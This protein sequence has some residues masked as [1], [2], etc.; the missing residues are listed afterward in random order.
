MF[1][2]MTNTLYQIVK[3]KTQKNAFIVSIVLNNNHRMFS[4][5]QVSVTYRSFAPWET[6]ENIRTVPL[7]HLT[8]NIQQLGWMSWLKSNKQTTTFWQFWVP[9]SETQTKI[10]R[11]TT[12]WNKHLWQ[13]SGNT[14]VPNQINN[15]NDM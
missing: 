13:G 12:L 4:Y 1:M 5:I 15:L 14:Y 8:K 7:W 9:L 2:D 11:Q 3:R 10:C 6:E